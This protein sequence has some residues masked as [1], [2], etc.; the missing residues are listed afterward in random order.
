MNK[1]LEIKYQKTHIYPAVRVNAKP[2]PLPF[3]AASIL[4]M[5]DTVSYLEKALKVS[6]RGATIKLM[7]YFALRSTV[8][9]YNAIIWILHPSVYELITLETRDSFPDHSLE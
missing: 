6:C 8:F 2:F 7:I 9:D 4:T 1:R 5:A 3:K